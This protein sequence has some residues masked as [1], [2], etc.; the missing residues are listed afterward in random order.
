MDWQKEVEKRKDQLIEDLRGLLAIRS[1]L[2]ES[3]A[4]EDAPFG[5]E[6]KKALTY[7]LDLG[8]R[9][10]YETEEVENVAGHLEMGQGEESV[11]ILCHVDIVPEGEGWSYPPFE[12]VIDNERIY[13]RGAIDDKGPTMAAYYAMNII[14]ELGFTLNKRVR[15]IIGTDE[16]S[17]WRCVNTYFKEEEMPTIGFAPDADFPIIHAEKGL[18]DMVVNIPGSEVN[19]GELALLSFQS[20]QRFNMVPDRAK[21][22]LSGEERT[23]HWLQ[24]FRDYLEENKLTGG[25]EVENGHIVLTVEGVSAHAMEPE[26]GVNAG[27]HLANILAK[28][29]LDEGGQKFVGFLSSSF[30]GQSRGQG[31]GFRY[32]DDITGDL[33]VN[34]GTMSYNKESGGKV[35]VNMRYPVTFEFLPQFDQWKKEVEALSYTLSLKTHMTPHHVAKDDPFIQT[36]SKVYEE[37]TGEKAELLT[38]GGGTYARSLET[39]V[40]FGAMFPGRPDVAHQKDEYMELEDLWK[41]TAIYAQAI[42]ELAVEK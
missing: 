11:G 31:I 16:E 33:T 3:T 14:K 29:P 6:V 5:P 4:T 13:A 17:E 38:I 27:L 36:L 1:V 12:G 7:M 34:I 39:G 9:D 2:D 8:K 21:A 18:V 35:G 37:Q 26:N 32:S 20:G 23:T 22:I 30:F 24:M 40:A 15:M 10:G 28:L 19:N 41:A 42:Y 25:V